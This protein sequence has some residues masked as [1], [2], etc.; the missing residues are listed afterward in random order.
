VRS[1][2]LTEF[3]AYSV[4]GTV[5]LMPL[6]VLPAM[7]GVLVDEAG[8]SESFAGWVASAN[9]FGG[10]LAGLLIALRIHRLDLRRIAALGL[11]IAIVGDVVSAYVAAPS[12]WF[13]LLRFFTGLA[14]GTAHVAA[15][16]AFAR[17]DDVE[18]GYG[19]FVTLQFIVSGLGLYV[20]P[21][22]SQQL[23]VS[24]MYLM[25]AV[26]EM[27]ALLLLGKLPGKASD[28]WS[29]APQNTEL[30]VLLAG[31]TIVAM[32]GY[33]MF[34]AANT[35]QFTYFERL[36]V[37]LDYSDRQIGTAL[38]VA[39]LIGIPGAFTIVVIG[40]R[41]GRRG[42]LAFG[43]AVAITGLVL[44]IT[45]RSYPWYFAAS[46][47]LGFSWAFCLPYFQSLMASLDPDGSA[48]AA[49]SSAATIGGAGGPG[50]AALIVGDGNYQYVFMLSIVLFS[51][52]VTCFLYSGRGTYEQG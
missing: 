9:F 15:L 51:I 21:V 19:L 20:L 2:N 38:L 24:G 29:G 47:C 46:C 17:H 4:I 45:T 31:V 7:V 50:L 12:E 43:I 39:S 11:A 35:A 8:L 32:L 36:G 6:L 22:Y 34:E 5:T 10:A 14:A 25:F 37:A 44:L 42:P 1:S 26:L 28:H 27:F 52:A 16:S 49:G 18:R 3:S 23:G 48:I 40:K 41:L 33:G 30:G 13:L